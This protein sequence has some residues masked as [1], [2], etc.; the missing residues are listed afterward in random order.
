MSRG[1][2]LYALCIISLRPGNTEPE[3]HQCGQNV[4]SDLLVSP[5]LG[6]EQFKTMPIFYVAVEDSNPDSHTFTSLFLPTS[7]LFSLKWEISNK[8]FFLPFPFAW[9]ILKVCQWTW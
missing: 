8:D 9:G 5:A 7:N 3:A 2:L 6:L 1:F 4:L